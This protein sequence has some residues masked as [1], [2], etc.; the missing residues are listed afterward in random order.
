MAVAFWL[1]PFSCFHFDRCLFIAGVKRD[2][3][4]GDNDLFFNEK[5][6]DAETVSFLAFAYIEA[7]CF[8]VLDDVVNKQTNLRFV[9]FLLSG[10]L[11]EVDA[12]WIKMG[13]E[14]GWT[15]RQQH[16]NSCHGLFVWTVF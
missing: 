7:K 8:F 9:S 2:D 13:G 3:S 11:M 5:D 4:T 16:A 12:T 14:M 1:I 10:Y 15:L 6:M